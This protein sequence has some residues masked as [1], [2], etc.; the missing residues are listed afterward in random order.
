MW[1]RTIILPFARIQ[2]VETASG[3]VERL[4]GL[5]RVKCF[6]AGGSSADLAMLGLDAEQARRVRQYLLEQIREDRTPSPVEEGALRG[7]TE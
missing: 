3:P 1:R 6:T 4:F 7:K 5:M 2:H